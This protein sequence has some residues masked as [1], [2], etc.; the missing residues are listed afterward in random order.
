MTPTK[1]SASP[2]PQIAELGRGGG[3]IAVECTS[4]LEAAKDQKI[5]DEYILREKLANLPIEVVQ[6]D[7]DIMPLAQL[8]SL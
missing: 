4:A 2:Q 7:I 3:L 1:T 8:F 6:T 5:D